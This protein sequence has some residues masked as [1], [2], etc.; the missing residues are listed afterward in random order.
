MAN[1]GIFKALKDRL[2]KIERDCEEFEAD[3]GAFT[4]T[5]TFSNA[6][7]IIYCDASKSLAPAKFS[8]MASALDGTAELYA[9]AAATIRYEADSCGADGKSVKALER[10]FADLAADTAEARDLFIE[11]S[12]SSILQDSYE[13]Y[14]R[15]TGSDSMDPEDMPYGFF[16]SH[17]DDEGEY[18]GNKSF[19]ESSFDGGSNP[20]R[21]RADALIEKIRDLD[22][23]ANDLQ[24]TLFGEALVMASGAV[25]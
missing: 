11:L 8:G 14:M 7:P 5:S 4:A 13:S 9:T 24:L 21:A 6:D 10:L 2:D 1:T 12:E 23:K 25:I 16:D 18:I 22:K 19:S 3:N 20:L 15:E 17:Y